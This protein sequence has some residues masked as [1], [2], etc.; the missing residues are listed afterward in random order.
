MLIATALGPMSERYVVHACWRRW[1]GDS[2]DCRIWQVRAP[3]GVHR[4]QL[5]VRCHTTKVATG[6]FALCG[7]G[8]L[9]HH[10]CHDLSCAVFLSPLV[11]LSVQAGAV[12]RRSVPTGDGGGGHGRAETFR[13]S[14]AANSVLPLVRYLVRRPGESI[15]SFGIPH[16]PT[17]SDRISFVRSG[18][19]KHPASVA[20]AAQA[21]GDLAKG[22]RGPCLGVLPLAADR[23]GS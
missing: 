20:V 12:L 16:L 2:V 6:A 18:R 13:N 21:S 15:D 1:P 14:S 17:A 23:H 10:R 19:R 11:V 4:S 5:C 7:G 8:R 9:Q 22:A 3:P